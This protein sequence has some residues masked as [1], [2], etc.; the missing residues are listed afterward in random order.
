MAVETA[1]WNRDQSI[2]SA[3]STWD[4]LREK[5]LWGNIDVYKISKKG[6]LRSLTRLLP[7]RQPPPHPG[8]QPSS[9]EGRFKTNNRKSRCTRQG[10][11]FENRFP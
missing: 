2:H 3:W 5:S 11:N 1:A 4:K 10:T 6:P 7:H 9:G 8:P